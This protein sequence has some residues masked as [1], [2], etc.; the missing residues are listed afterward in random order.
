LCGFSEEHSSGVYHECPA[1]HENKQRKD[2]DEDEDD[3]LLFR[4]A[5][6]ITFEKNTSESF[7]IT[8]ATIT[9][10][11]TT[12]N[13]TIIDLCAETHAE[14]TTRKHARS[15]NTEND[16]HAAD[17]SK[18]DDE[19]ESSSEEQ[20]SNLDVQ[21][22]NMRHNAKNMRQEL[23]ILYEQEH[24]RVN[25]FFSFSFFFISFL[26]PAFVSIKILC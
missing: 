3:K 24:D 13:K 8:S 23:A 6:K 26:F 25:F 1:C 22:I 9:S 7:S 12:S 20:Q 2:P 10:E 11:K 21:N 14:S 17:T 4:R 18:N 16:D 15:E 19:E 5:K